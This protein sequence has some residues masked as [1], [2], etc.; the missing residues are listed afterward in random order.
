MARA[1][2]VRSQHAVPPPGNSQLGGRESTSLVD[3]GDD[4][5]ILGV[6]KWC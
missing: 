3:L 1:S 2:D 4:D 5:L 6:R